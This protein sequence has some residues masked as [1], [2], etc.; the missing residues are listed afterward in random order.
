VLR[1]VPGFELGVDPL[2]IVGEHDGLAGRA[3]L[4][5]PFGP[6]HLIGEAGP[7]EARR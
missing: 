2:S 6:R 3:E 5:D 1:V 4:L 7:A